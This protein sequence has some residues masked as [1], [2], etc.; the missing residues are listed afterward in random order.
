MLGYVPQEN[1]LTTFPLWKWPAS[2]RSMTSSSIALVYTAS[3]HD[4]L[5]PSLLLFWQQS[6]IQIQDMRA[7]QVTSLLFGVGAN[8]QTGV[9]SPPAQIL[10]ELETLSELL[11]QSPSQMQRQI[12]KNG[13]S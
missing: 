3:G 13:R 6:L 1:V 12:S 11:L 10:D 4:A 2:P 8:A 9:I 5:L 7:I